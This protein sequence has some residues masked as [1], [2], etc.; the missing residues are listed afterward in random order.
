MTSTSAVTAGKVRARA[1]RLPTAA[2]AG[3]DPG[4]A[5]IA[6][7]SGRPS[8]RNSG[9]ISSSRIVCTARIQNSTSWY[10][11]T[12]DMVATTTHPEAAGRTLPPA[13][14]AT[15]PPNGAPGATPAR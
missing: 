10:T 9:A 13:R 6:S 7:D 14:P 5:A 11:P 1:G 12:K 3:P 2:P 15:V 4:A 8:A